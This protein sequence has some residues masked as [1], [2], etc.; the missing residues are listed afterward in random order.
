MENLRKAY[1]GRSILR[2]K[3]RRHDL[4]DIIFL[5]ICYMEDASLVKSLKYIPLPKLQQSKINLA[6]VEQYKKMFPYY[7]TII[8][9][10]EQ[11][12]SEKEYSVEKEITEEVELKIAKLSMESLQL[13]KKT[14]KL[15]MNGKGIIDNEYWEFVLS[16]IYFKISETVLRDFI[17]QRYER[18]GR[19]LQKT[20]SAKGN[21]IEHVD[22]LND[23]IFNQIEKIQI[24]KLENEEQDP[25]II[26]QIA[27]MPLTQGEMLIHDMDP[28]NG[29]KPKYFCRVLCGIEWSSYN[30]ANFTSENLPDTQILGYKFSIFYPNLDG[31]PDYEKTPDS[32]SKDHEIVV[33]KS[34]KPYAILR[35]R[36]LKKEWETNYKR[37]FNCVFE[38]KVLHLEFKFK[39]FVYRP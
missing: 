25:W 32:E 34:S 5:H 13:V 18:Y 14:V 28:D 26:E 38:N 3:Q 37:G 7:A 19:V 35:F 36:I 23:L 22:E 29:I 30:Q 21:G 2:L 8:S 10:L 1:A 4:S 12:Y 31:V 27:K 17:H 24:M 6:D 20:L 15:R 9:S 33:F 39:K 11:Y 16:R